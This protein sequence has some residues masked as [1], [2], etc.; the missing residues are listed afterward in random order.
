MGQSDLTGP[1]NVTSPGAVRNV[2]FTK[3]LAGSLRR[4]ALFRVPGWA[5]KLALGGFGGTLVASARV[6][7]KRL[8][9]A[10]YGFRYAELEAALEDLV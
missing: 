6:A 3:L 7:P 2:E 5:L 4:P 10:G 1:V 9:D 8:T